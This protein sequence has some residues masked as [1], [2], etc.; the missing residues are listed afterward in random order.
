MQVRI[1]LAEHYLED[2]MQQ[3]LGNVA[4]DD[5]AAPD[6]RFD[7]I[8]LHVQDNDLAR[9]GH[10]TIDT[11]VPENRLRTRSIEAKPLADESAAARPVAGHGPDQRLSSALDVNIAFV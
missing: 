8:D 9:F 11:T 10:S 7:V 6:R 4:I 5:D 1:G 3:A 2:V